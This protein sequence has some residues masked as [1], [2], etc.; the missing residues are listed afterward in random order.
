MTR[1]TT[2]AWATVAGVAAALAVTGA[3]VASAGG[4]A[5]AAKATEHLKANPN[6]ELKFNKKKLSAPEGKVTIVMKN[7]STSMTKHGIGVE[8]KGVDK[9]GKV[10]KPGK[11]SSITVTLKPGKYEYYCPVHDHKLAG[12]TGTLTVK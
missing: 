6:G 8:G 5:H 4:E 2:G 3:G 1:S 11:S 7:P 12:M 9:D 10:V